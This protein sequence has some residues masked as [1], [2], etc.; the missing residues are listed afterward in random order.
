MYKDLKN[1]TVVITGGA[2]GIGLSTAE[3]FIREKAS[4]IILDIDEEAGIKAEDKLGSNALFVKTDVT[5]SEAIKLALNKGLEKFG[6][7][8][9]LVNNAG[10]IHYANA[11]TCMEE[12]WDRVMNINLKSYYL[13]AKYTVPIMKKNTGGVIINVGSAQSFISS[14]NMVHYTTAKSAVLGLTRALAIDFA[15]EIRCLSICP[16]TVDTPM[17]R[18]A[19]AEASNPEQIHQDSI[20]MHVLKRIAK[21]EEIAEMIVFATSNRCAFMT[22]QHIRVDGG[23]GIQIPGS[24]E[25]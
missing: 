11:V 16:G 22:G 18:N 8:H 3:V 6:N 17:A 20:D 14:A 13:M 21:S 9:H 7:I 25:E 4:V 12:D 15:P 10:I 1:K 23:L 2:K 5:N 24:V 19:W